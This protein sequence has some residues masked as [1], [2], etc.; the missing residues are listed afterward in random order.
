MLEGSHPPTVKP[1]F[2]SSW[3]ESRTSTTWQRAVLHE[4]AFVWVRTPQM[5]KPPKQ[6]NSSKQHATPLFY[7]RMS[8]RRLRSPS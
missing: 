8:L 3:A 4:S 5:F 6:G 1:L 2:A 7:S